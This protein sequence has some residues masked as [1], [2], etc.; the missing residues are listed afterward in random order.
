MFTLDKLA[1]KIKILAICAAMALVATACD[2][3]DDANIEPVETAYV[4]LYQASPDAPDLDIVVDNRRINTYP[5]NYTDH[6]GYLRFYTGERNLKFGPYGASNVVT[7]T[8]VTFEEGNAY[9]VFVVDEY[10]NLGILMFEDNEEPPAEGNTLVRF[11]NLS[12]DAPSVDLMVAGETEAMF[13]DQSFKEISGFMEVT[14]DQYDFEVTGSEDGEVLL[15]VPDINLQAGWY[16]TVIVRGYTSP[17][18]GN[19]NIL[20]AEVIVN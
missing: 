9:S 7:D 1:T 13:A 15:N 12:P 5:F 2:D 8:T 10:T 3:D 6:T 19:N 11:I 16:Y 20:S 18:A 4:S 14:A 17:P